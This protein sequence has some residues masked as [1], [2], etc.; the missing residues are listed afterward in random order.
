MSG[1]VQ[2]DQRW[3]IGSSRGLRSASRILTALSGSMY[4]SLVRLEKPIAPID[5]FLLF[6]E[7]EDLNNLTADRIDIP[8]ERKECAIE[9]REQLFLR[10]GVP[11]RDI[12]KNVHPERRFRAEFRFNG[13]RRTPEIFV[14]QLV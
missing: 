13:L 11:G 7:G 2:I 3:K 5:E 14:H 6:Q 12:R 8:L 9:E 1:V 10:S 4:R